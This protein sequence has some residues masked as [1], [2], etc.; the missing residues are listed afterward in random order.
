[1]SPDEGGAPPAR[2]LVVFSG[3]TD[4]AWLRL[5]RPGFRHCFV[6]VEVEMGWLCLNPLAH[7]TIMDFW[8]LSPHV[9]LAAD[10]RHQ[11]LVV[12]E[13]RLVLPARRQA[14]ILPFSCVEAVKRVLGIHSLGILTPWQLYRHLTQSGK[15]S[16]HCP[17]E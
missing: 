5:L 15:K 1:M 14:P 8:P 12:V 17:S 16:L 6:V 2:A 11:D 10:F 4:L 7:R 9:D 13:T 3:R